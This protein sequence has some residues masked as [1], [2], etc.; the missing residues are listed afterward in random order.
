MVEKLIGCIVTQP[1][2]YLSPLI[3]KCLLNKAFSSMQSM[4]PKNMKQF[5]VLVISNK[6]TFSYI[7]T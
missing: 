4:Y 7:M 3:I 6:H 1:V 5:L 2:T